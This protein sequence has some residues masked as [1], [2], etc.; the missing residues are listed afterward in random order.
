[1]KTLQ[2]TLGYHYSATQARSDFKY[3]LNL[4]VHKDREIN[5][6]KCIKRLQED[7][8]DELLHCNESKRNPTVLFHVLRDNPVLKHIEYEQHQNKNKI[9]LVLE[10]CFNPEEDRD[11][12]FQMLSAL[13]GNVVSS[14]AVELFQVIHL[15]LQKDPVTIRRNFL[16]GFSVSTFLDSQDETYDQSVRENFFPLAKIWFPISASYPNRLFTDQDLEFT[17]VRWKQLSD[18]N[19][20]K[21]RNCGIEPHRSLGISESYDVPLRR[22]YRKNGLEFTA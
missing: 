15:T 9:M 14:Q 10:H 3:D 13:G 11:Y 5:N 8:T 20:V 1:M 16:T 2:T 7:L 4:Y 6:L 21:V 18:S 22:I 19:E 12:V 17:S